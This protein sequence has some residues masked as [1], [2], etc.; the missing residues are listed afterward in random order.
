MLTLD[1]TTPADASAL[2]LDVRPRTERSKTL[3][4]ERPS[5]RGSA[6]AAPGHQ[7]EHQPLRASYTQSKLLLRTRTRGGAG[8]GRP[9]AEAQ[10]WA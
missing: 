7:A 1:S 5:L 8:G 6:R 9:S 10:P 3:Q 2:T 4:C